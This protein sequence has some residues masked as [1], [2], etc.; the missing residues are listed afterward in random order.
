MICSAKLIILFSLIFFFRTCLNCRKPPQKEEGG[1][2]ISNLAWQWRIAMTRA[3]LL[4]DV[5]IAL[6][7]RSTPV[8][9]FFHFDFICNGSCC[10]FV[11]LPFCVHNIS[12][13]KSEKFYKLIKVA[14][15]LNFLEH[16]IY[17]KLFSWFAALPILFII[18][19]K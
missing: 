10:F 17:F 7:T 5:I 6:R 1:L 9:A 14:L 8:I 3:K 16:K 4:Y 15:K 19:D 11:L 18:K 2:K 13:I 12:T